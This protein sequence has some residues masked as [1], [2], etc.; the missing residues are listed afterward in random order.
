[1]KDLLAPVSN[2]IWHSVPFN[3]YPIVYPYSDIRNDPSALILL[4]LNL[5]TF[6]KYVVLKSD[7]SPHFVVFNISDC[8]PLYTS[9]YSS[10]NLPGM[11]PKSNSNM[12]PSSFI[13][14]FLL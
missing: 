10:F 13:Y 3:S 7:F 12:S 14:E 4:F 5:P 9:S 6:P 2:G 11:S 8:I 1:M